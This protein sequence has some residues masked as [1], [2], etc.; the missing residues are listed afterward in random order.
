MKLWLAQL[1]SWFVSIGKYKFQ[2]ENDYQWWLP[3]VRTGNGRTRNLATEYSKVATLRPAADCVRIAKRSNNFSVAGMRWR[4]LKWPP[5]WWPVRL[6]ATNLNP[7]DHEALLSQTINCRT[8]KPEVTTHTNMAKESS[9][10]LDIWVVYLIWST[11][12]LNR[13][14]T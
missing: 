14:V 13:C 8:T 4:E 7:L 9:E 11:T 6:F 2:I 10:V 3:K 12:P 1:I 5:N